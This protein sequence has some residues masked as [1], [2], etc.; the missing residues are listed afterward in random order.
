MDKLGSNKNYSNK[1]FE[2]IRHIDKN[3]N[4]YWSAR[5]LM[6]MLECNKWENF[7]KVIN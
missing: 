6:K 5:E 4:E 7:E 1:T 3:G 2:D